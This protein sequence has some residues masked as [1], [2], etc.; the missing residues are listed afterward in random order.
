MQEEELK[1]YNGLQK[2]GALL[3]HSPKYGLVVVSTKL[4][5]LTVTLP[6]QI[7]VTTHEYLN[8]PSYIPEYYK[9]PNILELQI[10]Y[11]Q[12]DNISHIL[13]EVIIFRQK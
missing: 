2:Q 13:S 3:L 6:F 4:P 7:L 10:E 12:Q 8:R 11:Y 5:N 1:S 9:G